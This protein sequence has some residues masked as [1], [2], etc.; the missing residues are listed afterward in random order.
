MSKERPTDSKP[1][2]REITDL[3]RWKLYL[4]KIIYPDHKLMLQHRRWI[5]YTLK[6]A[7]NSLLQR[8]PGREGR[9]LTPFFAYF[10]HPEQLDDETAFQLL[11][12]AGSDPAA[13]LHRAPA[14][15]AAALCRGG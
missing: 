6:F 14:R 7:V 13:G 5:C 2:P 8:C 10:R 15:A 3:D 9:F 4:D 1:D 12:T 11:D